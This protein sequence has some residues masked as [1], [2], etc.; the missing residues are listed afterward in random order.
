VNRKRTVTIVDSVVAHDDRMKQMHKVF[1][2]LKDLEDSLTSSSTKSS[3]Q[4][5]VFNH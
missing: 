5:G 2:K 3:Q 1:Q 4:L